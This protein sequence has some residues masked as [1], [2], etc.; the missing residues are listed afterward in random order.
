MPYADIFM[1]WEGFKVDMI[2]FYNSIK[3]KIRQLFRLMGVKK[4]ISRYD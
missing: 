4:V 1:C 2:A 3:I